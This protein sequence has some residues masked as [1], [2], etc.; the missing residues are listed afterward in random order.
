MLPVAPTAAMTITG[1]AAN[2]VAPKGAGFER[3]WILIGR[4]NGEQMEADLRHEDEQEIK[5]NIAEAVHRAVCQQTQS[6][7]CGR[8]LDY[9]IAGMALAS[10]L[11][12]RKYV[13]QAGTL[14]LVADPPDGVVAMEPGEDGF[15]RGEF[16]CWFGAP[17]GNGKM[18]EFID[19][20]S[21]HYRA[22]VERCCQNTEA[23]GRRI[24]W[25]R[26][27]DPPPF[28][29]T[30][31]T[32]PD[33][34]RVVP[35]AEAVNFIY[36]SGPELLLSYVPVVKL[37]WKH[38]HAL[39]GQHSISP[40]AKVGRNQPCPCGSGRKYK[41]CCL[42]K[43]G[44]PATVMEKSHAVMQMTANVFSIVCFR[45]GDVADYDPARAMKLGDARCHVCG[46]K[47]VSV[48]SDVNTGTEAD[49][50]IV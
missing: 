50:T 9:A 44:V 45:C 23:L 15:E 42:R 17:A 27:D 34:M 22:L 4:R 40:T 32:F 12:G 39:A 38:Y 6:D 47:S 26:E 37:A 14:Y 43:S 18:A 25:T 49:V 3:G 21:R 10:K 11:L 1:T 19:L 2:V 7:G 41:R 35:S 30:D 24:S 8:C 20:S 36:N 29:W 46:S 5:M 13:V 31:G 48:I 16:H 28:I 33:M